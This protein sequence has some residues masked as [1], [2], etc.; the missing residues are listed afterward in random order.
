MPLAHA[1]HLRAQ[2]NRLEVGCDAERVH[3]RHQRIRDFT[4]KSLLHREAARE[5]AHEPGDLRDA[6][7]PLAGDVADVGETVEAQ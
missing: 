3:H 7:D 2:M 1:A 4:P 6:D 5:Q